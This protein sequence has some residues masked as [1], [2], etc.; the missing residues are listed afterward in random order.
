M[1]V[2]V[3]IFLYLADSA[4]SGTLVFTQLFYLLYNCFVGISMLVNSALFDQ[5]VNEDLRPA[6][7][8]YLPKIYCETKKRE[9]FSY[10]RYVVWSIA[11]IL[12]AAIIYYF[13]RFALLGAWAIDEE[14]RI[15]DIKTAQISNGIA[16]NLVILVLNYIDTESHTSFFVN[17][18]LIFAT[19]LPTASYFIA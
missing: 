18:V 11:A 4:F 16:L 1:A 15:S 3:V 7:F 13:I 12:V 6:L 2:T 17:F 5:D 14:G 10:W 9:L 8:P 19:L